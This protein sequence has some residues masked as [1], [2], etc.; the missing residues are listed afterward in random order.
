MINNKPIIGVL[1]DWQ[2]NGSFSKRPHYALRQAYFDAISWAGGVPIGLAYDEAHKQD[3][4]SL[5]DGML[6]PGGNFASP[7]EWYVA[8][9]ETPYAPSPRAKYEVRLI[10]DALDKGVP[11][12]GI[13]GGMQVMGAAFGCKFTGDLHK[14]YET[15]IDHK[16]GTPATEFAFDVTIK[17]DTKLHDIV[18]SDTMQVNAAHREAVVKHPDSVIVSAKNHIGVVEALEIPAYDFAIGVQWHPEFFTTDDKG[19]SGHGKIFKALIAAAT[20]GT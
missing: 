1:L 15:D 19:E 20:D 18:G 12:L 14:Y 11:V 10:K 17:S 13:C 3:Y 7:A 8:G 4:L 6:C 16:K 9:E 2:E 5:I